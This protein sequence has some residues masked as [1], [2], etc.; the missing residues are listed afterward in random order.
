MRY[1]VVV[2]GSGFGGSV[3]ALRLAEK[4]YSVGVLE[5]GRRFADDEFP[6]TSWRAR[7]FLW[8]PR[9]GCFG[10]QRITLLR[11]ADRKAG[12]GVLVLSGAGVGGGSL[13]YANTL[14]EPLDAFYADPQ[15]RDITDWRDEL[16]RHYDQ[17]KRMLGVTTYP[18]DTRAD[19]AVR[20]VAERMGVAHTY[21]PTPVGVHIGRPGERVA[22]PYFGGAGPDRTGC[23]HCGSCMT[24]CRH[25][26]K[27]TLVKNY[28][29][30]AERLGV[31][32]HPL[33]T[34]TAVRPDPAGGYAVHTERTGA[35]LRKRREVI[36]ADQVVFA[37]GALGT[38]R[39]LHEMKATGALPALS[40][41]L[42]ELT[43]T[44]SEAILGASVL[45]GAA[46][47]RGLDFTEGVAI[48]SSFHPDPQTHIEPVRY[49]KGSNAMG[50]LQ[51]LLV[52][53]GPRRARRWLG[54]IVRQPVLAA[55]MLS[56]RRWSERTV[57]ALVMQSVDN[58]LTTRLRRGRL[59]SGP[60][61]GAPNPTWIP[62]GNTAA[63]LLAEEI[64]GTPG[65]A[66][67]EPFNIPVTAHI[68]G[69]AVIGA[70]PDEGVVDPWHRVY[71]HP[72]LHVVDG[73]A[74]SANLGVNP[75]LTITAQAE[76]AMSYWPNK[77]EADPRP[78]LGSAYTRV[79]P[80]PPR[81]PAVPA[82]APAA[83][84]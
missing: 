58:S 45:P 69:G 53:G 51:S 38:Q 79:A 67:T 25:G 18:I 35:W 8:A 2:I 1:D 5:A 83:L 13:V 31:Q 70:T 77:G 37:A 46:R 55:R 64:G 11:S 47:R 78:E 62:A 59:V 12:G 23:S 17:A 22:D 75:S 54:S 33:T 34:V 16:A 72:G 39:L 82:H 28:L 6:R 14:Y 21:H 74:V 84:R 68:L 61:H 29:W 44:N 48:T 26:A 50:L 27:N 9:L 41:R 43:R 19:Q 49:G 80:V 20:A 24:G 65:G 3:T 81:R 40:P 60:G 76:R 4:G 15:W 66:V 7:R 73:A 10:L 71:G 56:V 36:H 57:I 63:R 42:G 32:V 30:L 52:D